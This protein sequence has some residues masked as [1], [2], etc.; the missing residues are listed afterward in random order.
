MHLQMILCLLV[1]HCTSPITATLHGDN[2]LCPFLQARIA[3]K[4]G[5]TQLSR[6]KCARIED[7]QGSCE[8]P[9]VHVHKYCTKPHCHKNSSQPILHTT[10]S[11]VIEPKLKKMNKI[12]FFNHSSLLY[13]LPKLSTNS[14]INSYSKHTRHKP[15]THNTRTPL[16]TR[17]KR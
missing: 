8:F 6:N 12:Y 17:Q 13:S 14:Q 16:N 7:K 11:I 9:I 2:N 10:G 1:Q 15:T 5:F 3:H 4:R